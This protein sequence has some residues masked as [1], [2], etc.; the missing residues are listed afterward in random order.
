MLFEIKEKVHALC[1]DSGIWRNAIIEKVSESEEPHHVR[2]S[3]AF[4]GFSGHNSK[5]TFDIDLDQ[6]KELW[7][8][9][10]Y[11]DAIEP[12]AGRGTRV[13]EEPGGPKRLHGPETKLSGTAVSIIG[14]DGVPRPMEI[15]LNDPFSQ[16]MALV[17]PTGPRSEH[18]RLGW[19][20]VLAL[21]TTPYGLILDGS[22]AVPPRSSPPR[23]KVTFI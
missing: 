23:K 14:Q 12:S 1:M 21:P 6:Q 17:P 2:V 15:A 16:R 20:D 5:R 3:V 10:K 22:A 19:N 4:G 9:R 18:E 13:K 11:F 7:V 8:I